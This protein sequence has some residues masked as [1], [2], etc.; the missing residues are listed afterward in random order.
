MQQNRALECHFETKITL[1][2]SSHAPFAPKPENE[3]TLATN[4]FPGEN[5]GYAYAS[6]CDKDNENW[7]TGD[8]CCGGWQGCVFLSR[9]GV[10]DER[11][12]YP[13]T[14]ASLGAHRIASRTPLPARYL[15][16]D[17]NGFIDPSFTARLTVRRSR[18]T[19]DCYSGVASS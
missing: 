3:T 4:A 12:S 16:I 9:R 11:R 19:T 10:H 6:G 5:P 13:S 8:A 14:S 15:I 17:S 18:C 7:T 1:K 2:C